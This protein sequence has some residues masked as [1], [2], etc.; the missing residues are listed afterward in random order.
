M[1]I[2]ASLRPS[3][4]CSRPAAL[5]IRRF[6]GNPPGQ[7]FRT[8][9]AFDTDAEFV[10]NPCGSRSRGDSMMNAKFYADFRSVVSDFIGKAVGIVS[11]Y[12]KK[13]Q[14]PMC[15]FCVEY[16]DQGSFNARMETEADWVKRDRIAKSYGIQIGN[17]WLDATRDEIIWGIQ[18]RRFSAHMKC[19][20]A[21]NYREF[22]LVRFFPAEFGVDA[23]EAQDWAWKYRVGDFD[24]AATEREPLSDLLQ[25]YWAD[26][27]DNEPQIMEALEG[28]AEGEGES[29][30]YV[31]RHIDRKFVAAV[32]GA[33]RDKEEK[34]LSIPHT[35]EFIAFVA[36]AEATFMP[37]TVV[38]GERQRFVV[39]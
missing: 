33:I 20:R 34:I 19:R 15:A 22:E 5:R 10:S 3:Q 2:D 32:E 28:E 1:W 18:D 14:S 12:V 9:L 38:I 39:V 16:D 27:L 8:D 35:A 31:R 29:Y 6:M 13:Q 4:P 7:G 26:V 17:K 25:A 30:N 36:V 23:P 37:D 24:I 11:R 21:G